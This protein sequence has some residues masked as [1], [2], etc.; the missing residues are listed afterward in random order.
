MATSSLT[1]DGLLTVADAHTVT[2]EKVDIEAY[3]AKFN[4]AIK[5]YPTRVGGWAINLQATFPTSTTIKLRAQIKFENLIDACYFVQ[6]WGDELPDMCAIY[7][8]TA[9]QESMYF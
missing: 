7:L 5:N 6:Q 2:G 9:T 1:L 4:T 8:P 3:K